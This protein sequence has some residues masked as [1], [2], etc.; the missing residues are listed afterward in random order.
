MPTKDSANS[1]RRS[2]KIMASA[3]ALN[4]GVPRKYPLTYYHNIG[5]VPRKHPQTYHN[6]YFRIPTQRLPVLSERPP[7]TSQ[8]GEGFL[9]GEMFNSQAPKRILGSPGGGC[10]GMAR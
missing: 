5:G 8:P 3:T 6:T 10:K 1:E 7:S 4:R 2:P 9:G